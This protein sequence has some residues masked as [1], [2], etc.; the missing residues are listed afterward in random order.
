MNPTLSRPVILRMPCDEEQPRILRFPKR[1][2]NHRATRRRS[3][4]VAPGDDPVDADLS[5][6]RDRLFRMIVATE[7]DRSNGN[8]AS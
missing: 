3:T 4:L 2:K 6:V 7:W 8:R 1:G 5:A